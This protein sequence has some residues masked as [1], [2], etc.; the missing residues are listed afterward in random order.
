MLAE[1]KAYLSWLLNILGDKRCCFTRLAVF[2]LQFNITFGTHVQALPAKVSCFRTS[3]FAVCSFTMKLNFAK[4]KLNRGL[5]IGKKAMFG[6]FALP[7]S[8]KEKDSRPLQNFSPPFMVFKNPQNCIN[9]QTNDQKDHEKPSFLLPSLFIII[10]WPCAVRKSDT[11]SIKQ[12]I[13]QKSPLLLDTFALG[14]LHTQRL[15]PLIVCV[16]YI[17]CEC[18]LLQDGE[19]AHS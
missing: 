3:F 8:L 17:F 19:T 18:Q 16:P 5:S 13:I 10:C 6:A 1:I 2:P 11:N 7:Q 14:K 15:F 4:G 9:S 12:L